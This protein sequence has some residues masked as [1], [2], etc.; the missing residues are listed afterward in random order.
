MIVATSHSTLCFSFRS[1]LLPERQRDFVNDEGY[2]SW[3]FMSVH[4]WGEN[5]AGDWQINVYF[6]SENGHVTMGDLAVVLYG[7]DQVPESVSR[8]PEECD[9]ECV[10][11]CAARG[12]QY[13]D[14]CKNQRVLS[15]LRCVQY[16][17]GEQDIGNSNQTA[18]GS[19]DSCSM[20]GYCLNCKGRLLGLSIPLIALVTV[21]GMVL[22]VGS[23]TVSFILWTKFCRYNNDY[24]SI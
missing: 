22:L 9:S 19:S 7:T 16:C 20:G 3:P 1:I 5:P 15:D 23:I 8:I 2:Y 10:R 4:H 14:A 21:S 13:C 11:G 17:P 6:S 18:E 24:I 12:G